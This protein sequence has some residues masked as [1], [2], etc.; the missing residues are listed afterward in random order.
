MLQHFIRDVR[1]KF[2][3]PNLPH[4][5]DVGQNSDGGLSDFRSSSQSLIKGNCHNSRTRK[6]DMKLGSVTKLDKRNKTL[7]KKFDEDVISENYDVIVIF[8]IY[9][10]FVAIPKP[11]FGRMVCKIYIFS[12]GNLLFYIN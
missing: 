2:G 3:I 11:D 6:I 1:A 9:S 5:P 4:S 10:R 7:S 8:S 12:N